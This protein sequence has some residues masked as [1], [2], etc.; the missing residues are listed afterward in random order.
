MR[1]PLELRLLNE[2]ILAKR[3]ADFPLDTAALVHFQGPELAEMIDSQAVHAVFVLFWSEAS[4]LD[5]YALHIW[6][7]SAREWREAEAEG[8][9]SPGPIV[10]GAVECQAEAEVCRAFGLSSHASSDGQLH[11]L[12][13]FRDG[14]RIGQQLAI[15]EQ[16]F[17]LEW[18]VGGSR[19][20]IYLQICRM[21]LLLSGPLQRLSN[22]EQIAAA[23][24]GF[25]PG[26][27]GQLPALTL[28]LFR[29]EQQEEFRQF[30]RVS[31]LLAG[32]YHLAFALVSEG[33]DGARLRTLR[34]PMANR[35]EEG[36][37]AMESVDY[38]GTFDTPSLLHHITH[39]SVPDIVGFWGN[40]Y[41]TSKRADFLVFT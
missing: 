39:W 23:G 24:K 20:N 34:Q 37:M 2:R 18:S 27:S 41:K 25:L 29:D 5:K 31:A 38:I 26:F 40:L 9:H 36:Q 33:N 1:S 6:A 4:Q 3:R 22:A 10:L 21:R 28:G 12:M 7:N 15:G 13:A 11:Q 17:M 32:R 8:K 19:L 30:R 16:Q 14:H 35:A